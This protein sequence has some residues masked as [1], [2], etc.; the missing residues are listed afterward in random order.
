MSFSSLPNLFLAD[1]GPGLSL[2]P[3][4]LREACF[5]IRRNREH[6]LHQQRVRSL[7]EIIAHVAEQWLDP[8]NGFRQLAIKEGSTELGLGEATVRRGVDSFF[9]QL[10]VENLEGL[11][12]QDLGD[13]KRLDDFGA[14]SIEARGGRASYARGARLLAHV[15]AG[16]LP[17]P[18]LMSMVL[19]ILTKSAQFIKCP[20]TASIFPRL[21]AH[22]LAHVEPKLGSSME[23]ACW[24][25]GNAGLESILFA[26]ADCITATGSDETIESIRSR[27]PHRARFASYGHR[28]SFAYISGEMLTTYSVRRLARETANDVTAWNQLGC[29]S[30]HVIYVRDDGVVSPEGF[31][32]E[33]AREMELRE[34]TEP[35]GGLTIEESAAIAM[36][37]S[38]YQLRSA[39]GSD[40]RLERNRGESVFKDLPTSV[41]M[42]Q[43]EGS[44]AWTVV[45]DADPRFKHSCLNRFIYIK[46]V[47]R[48]SDVLHFAEPVRHQTSTVGLAAAETVAIECAR[49]LAHWGVSRICPLGKMQDPPLPWRHDGRP[50]LGDLITW[51]DF[52]Q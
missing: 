19:G 52:E 49:L 32:L 24:P 23:I 25:G 18:A 27:V 3:D 29:L 4:T 13:L 37:R 10:T 8:E 14:S 30:P 47:R 42:W 15:V 16:N 44:T 7:I 20:A 45:L 40:V 46:P 2:S 39:A 21:F 48:F 38:A 33:L 1:L 36:R 50:A 12:I 31:A 43:S 22:S 34:K 5:A 26:E 51:T 17:N 35:R 28:V 11:V 6:W 9:R 41:Q